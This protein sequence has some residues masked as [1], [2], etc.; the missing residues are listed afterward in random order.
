MS[1][2]G[3]TKNTSFCPTTIFTKLVVPP[4]VSSLF[5]YAPSTLDLASLPHMTYPPPPTPPTAR[6]YQQT[7]NASFGF[8]SSAP[9]PLEYTLGQ[10]ERAVQSILKPSKISAT[11]SEKLERPAKRKWHTELTPRLKLSRDHIR[12]GQRKRKVL[13][14]RTDGLRKTAHVPFRTERMTTQMQNHTSYTPPCFLMPPTLSSHNCYSFAGLHICS[15][16]CI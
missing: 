13:L 3:V 5:I 1:Q 8:T 11:R 16:P 4:P 14:P 9:R 6:P 15:R 12:L 10:K 2:T 7:A